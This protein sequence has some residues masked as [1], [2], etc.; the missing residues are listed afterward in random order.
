ML[1]LQTVVLVF[2]TERRDWIRFPHVG[3][4]LCTAWGHKTRYLLHL[5]SATISSW[6]S[7]MTDCMLLFTTSC[8]CALSSSL[9]VPKDNQTRFTFGVMS[10]IFS[11]HLPLLSVSPGFSLYMRRVS[12]NDWTPLLLGLAACLQ[13]WLKLSGLFGMVPIFQP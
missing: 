4:I 6:V 5:I 10:F 3:S 1:L 2:L 13:R 7:F 8:F 11:I 9:Y 12:F